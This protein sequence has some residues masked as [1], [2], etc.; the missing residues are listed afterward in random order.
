MTIQIEQP[1]LKLGKYGFLLLFL[2]LLIIFFWQFP[3][4]FI[5]PQVE[6][7]SAC[8]VQLYQVQGTL[9]KGSSSI[10]VSELN[11]SGTCK[12]P[13]ALTERIY[14]TT[15][16]QLFSAQCQTDISVSRSQQPIRIFFKIG[17]IQI[18]NNQIQLPANLL[19][20]LGSPWN[21]LHPQGGLDIHWNDLKISKNLD[22]LV[23]IKVINLSS[24]ISKVAPLG[25]YELKISLN[26]PITA[27]L[28]TLNGPLILNG[29]G[30]FNNQSLQF[31]G[32]ASSTPEA[33][34]SLTGLL[35]VIGIKN[36]DNYQ[37]KF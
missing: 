2:G 23:S 16:C 7:M 21:S 32:T 28:I 30:Q 37:L 22:G 5:S 13:S 4:S 19:E 11:E 26:S 31:Q 25:S 18:P 27:N 29:Q 20:S 24:A 34:N 15:H 1:T 36:G 6:K 12:A 10:G 8:K 33:K 14:W 17:S 9:W 35:S 3:I